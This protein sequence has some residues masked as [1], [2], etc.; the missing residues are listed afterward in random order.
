[1]LSLQS[2]PRL[3]SIALLLL[4]AQASFASVVFQRGF[5]IVDSKAQ[6][7]IA[8]WND[9]TLVY[10][11][12][13]CLVSK[14]GVAEQISVSGFGKLGQLRRLAPKELEA[15]PRVPVMTAAPKAT[16]LPQARKVPDEELR[17]M[18]L[19]PPYPVPGIVFL[20]AQF[21]R[22]PLAPSSPCVSV[23]EIVITDHRGRISRATFEAGKSPAIWVEAS[24]GE[25]GPIAWR[26]KDGDVEVSGTFEV[27][28]FSE[29]VIKE[30]LLQKKSFE[31]ME[32]VI[33]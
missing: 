12:G 20:Y 26:F 5:A 14:D 8:S 4:L 21:I 18:N 25:S 19:K 33:R 2:L 32:N 27:R 3:L 6:K 9:D 7:Q 13:Y 1:M 16:E 22:V 11:P 30:L 31:I 15:L 10:C 23:C 29:Q 28:E 24:K 17:N